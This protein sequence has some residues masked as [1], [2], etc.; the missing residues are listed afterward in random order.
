MKKIINKKHRGILL[1]LVLFFSST[2]FGAD[3][4][5]I[6]ENVILEKT[7]VKIEQMANELYQKTGIK[8]Y[9]VAKKSL[10]GKNIIEFEKDFS[11]KIKPPFVILILSL[12]DKKV[13]IYSSKNIDELFDKEA[14]LSP[15]PWEG[16]IIPLLTGKKKNVSV[17]AA[18]LNGYADLVEQ[19]SN[20]KNIKLDSAIGSTNKE[21][22]SF[23]NISI[24]GF[25][26][27]V[28]GWYFYRRI[29]NR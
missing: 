17:S 11:G 23:L 21:L 25:L 19:I 28:F 16:S 27:M 10:N 22:I 29:K 6:N 4:F 13:D 7:A 24:F 8:A 18:L 2:L 3:D 5:V 14:I 15:Y 12:D 9:L 26:L 20:S 1:L